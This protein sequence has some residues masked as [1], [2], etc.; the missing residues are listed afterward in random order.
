MHFLMW[1]KLFIEQQVVNLPA[2]LIIK[3]LLE[4]KQQHTTSNTL[5]ILCGYLFLSL[6]LYN[7]CLDD[8]KPL[9]ILQS[10]VVSYVGLHTLL[11]F[12]F[13]WCDFLLLP[14]SFNINVC[15]P[16]LLCFSVGR[17]TT[18]VKTTLSNRLV[19]KST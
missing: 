18:S 19:V 5:N 3:K 11:N 16:T 12:L 10:A 8:F 9:L 6:F 14:F 15:G 13:S 4:Y 1:V 7:R 17:R 2:K